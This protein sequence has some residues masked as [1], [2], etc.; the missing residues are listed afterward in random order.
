MVYGYSPNTTNPRSYN[1]LVE[2]LVERKSAVADTCW[3]FQPTWIGH[4]SEVII[5]CIEKG[6]KNKNIPVITEVLKSRFDLANDILSP[7][8]IEVISDNGV[9]PTPVIL[10]SENKLIEL[11]LP[12]YSYEEIIKKIVEETRDNFI[13]K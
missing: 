4:I 7:F 13:S 12:V 6:I 10:Q 8:G 5:Q 11:G 9:D 1:R 3:K 2:N